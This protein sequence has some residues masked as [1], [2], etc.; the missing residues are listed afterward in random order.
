MLYSLLCDLF[1]PLL[2]IV[3]LSYPLRGGLEVA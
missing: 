3:V 2:G 1:L